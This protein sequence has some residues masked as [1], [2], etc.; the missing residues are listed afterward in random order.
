VLW[1]GYPRNQ[2]TWEPEGSIV[3]SLSLLREASHYPP[4]V[5]VDS[6]HRKQLESRGFEI[7]CLAKADGTC[8]FRSSAYLVYG[9]ES[10]WNVLRREVLEWT[11]DNR[12]R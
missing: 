6:M 3:E 7:A 2:S 4:W 11:R 12:E 5:G 8:F 1:K 9:S 10:L